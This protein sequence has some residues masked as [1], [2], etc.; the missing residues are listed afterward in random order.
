[1]GMEAPDVFAVDGEEKAKRQYSEVYATKMVWRFRLYGC[2][3]T[4]RISSQLQFQRRVIL[5]PFI[6]SRIWHDFALL[7]IP[8]V[9]TRLCN[10][11]LSCVPNLAY[12]ATAVFRC[13]ESV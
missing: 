8:A 6:V 5:T 9:L 11:L 12:S 3:E 4:S 13:V 10:L 1:M 7:V 2:K